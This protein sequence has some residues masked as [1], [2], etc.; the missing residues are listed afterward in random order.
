MKFNKDEIKNSLSIEQIE[1]IVAELGGEP[2]SMGSFLTCR[3]ICHGGRF[4]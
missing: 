2:R 4:S 3:T 1:D